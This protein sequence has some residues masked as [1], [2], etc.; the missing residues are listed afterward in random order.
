MKKNK[1]II[2]KPKSY[3]FQLR[4]PCCTMRI[5]FSLCTPGLRPK[6]ITGLP[7]TRVLLEGYEEEFPEKKRVQE[8]QQRERDRE[9]RRRRQLFPLEDVS[10][11]ATCSICSA[12]STTDT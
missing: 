8:E 1:L 11:V 6:D 3:P 5:R 10:A 4:I 9:A 12:T 7:Q 2:S